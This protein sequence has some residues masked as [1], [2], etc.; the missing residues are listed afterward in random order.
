MTPARRVGGL[1]VP[2]AGRAGQGSLLAGR[3]RL[4]VPHHPPVG[5]TSRTLVPVSA[6]AFGPLGESDGDHPELARLAIDGSLATAW[7]TSWYTTAGFG[8]L[9]PGTGLL[10]DMGRPVTVTA[11]QVTLGTITGADVQLR[12]GGQP[13]QPDLRLVAHAAD[14]G[15]VVTISI[16]RPAAARYLLIWFTRLPPDGAGTYQASVY[17]VRLN[18]TA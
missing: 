3:Y 2:G 6:A 9:K 13:A 11:V 1:P 10:L 7:R 15:R 17:N 8:N 18:G 16:T 4:A 12:V 14:A 5:A